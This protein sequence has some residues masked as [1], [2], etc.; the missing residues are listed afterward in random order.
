[1]VFDRDC[2][3]HASNIVAGLVYGITFL[4]EKD[5]RKEGLVVMAWAIIWA[6]IGIFVIGPYLTIK[7]GL[8]P[9]FQ[10]IKAIPYQGSS[11]T[12]TALIKLSPRPPVDYKSTGFFIVKLAV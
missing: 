3:F 4:I 5:H 10:I 1:M 7:L 6:L 11:T 8:L 12:A 9:K 2:R